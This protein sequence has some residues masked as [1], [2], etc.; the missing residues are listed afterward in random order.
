MR[1]LSS[2]VQFPSY[3]RRKSGSTVTPAFPADIALESRLLL[4]A[5]VIVAPAS[6]EFFDMG[7][8]PATQEVG[9]IGYEGTGGGPNG[10]GVT[11]FAKLFEVNPTGSAFTAQT[12]VGLGNRVFVA[13]ISSD[14]SR[15][16]GSSNTPGSIGTGEGT[17]W[18]RDAIGIPIGIGA[19]DPDGRPRSITGY[20]SFGNAAWSGGVVGDVGGGYWAIKW[21][22]EAGVTPLANRTDRVEFAFDV[23]ESGSISVGVAGFEKPDGAAYYWNSTGIHRLDDTI[24]GALYIQQS[25]AYSISPN[26]SYVG[27]YILAEDGTEDELVQAAVWNSQRQLLRPK[28]AQGQ[29]FQG[30]VWDVSNHGYAVGQT[31]LGRGFIWHPSFDGVQSQFNGAQYFDD[32]LLAVSGTA[33]P[34]A[35]KTVKAIA[36]D[37]VDGQLLFILTDGTFPGIGFSFGP[38]ASAFVEVDVAGIADARVV[39]SAVHQGKLPENVV[40]TGIATLEVGLRGTSTL[41][42][43]KL[44]RASLFI[45]DDRN[46][47]SGRVSSVKI[48][49]VDGDGFKDAIITLKST[50]TLRNDTVRLKITGQLTD[51][52]RIDGSRTVTST[53]QSVNAY[54]QATTGTEW[55]SMLS[56]YTRGLKK[57]WW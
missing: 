1:L 38:G 8:D 23:S 16:A 32:W 56:A 9:I 13:G 27:G 54:W 2:L 17:T 33:M 14:G 42:V 10:I 5:K 22:P 40:S 15:L 24:P 51:G 55:K 39:T 45:G 36:E 53:T 11:K 20:K 7:F 52:T 12:L 34:F 35:S 50:G 43:T 29:P 3:R 30:V 37:P 28:D 26:S 46:S 48:K 6:Y 47:T 25:V 57:T 31:R 21:T 44:D 41:D 18:L 49:D 4:A 19:I